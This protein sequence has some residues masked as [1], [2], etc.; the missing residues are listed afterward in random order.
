VIRKSELKLT[1]KIDELVQTALDTD[2]V[3]WCD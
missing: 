2:E 3:I 1:E